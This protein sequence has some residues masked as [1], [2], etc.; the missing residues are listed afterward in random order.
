MS[1]WYHEELWRPLLCHFSNQPHFNSPWICRDAQAK[2]KTTIQP[3][4][5]QGRSLHC[6]GSEP[7]FTNTIY[8]LGW[9]VHSRRPGL[10][11][12]SDAQGL[13]ATS[14]PSHATISFRALLSQEQDLFLSFFL[15]LCLPSSPLSAFLI[16]IFFILSFPFLSKSRQHWLGGMR[17][18]RVKYLGFY[19][20]FPLK[21][22]SGLLE[23]AQLIKS[24]LSDGSDPAA[25][26][27]YSVQRV[28]TTEERAQSITLNLPVK[29]FLLLLL[30]VSFYFTL[31]AIVCGDLPHSK[32]LQIR[33]TDV[34]LQ[35][36][37]DTR[38]LAKWKQVYNRYFTFS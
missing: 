13:D 15:L 2:N 35:S 16:Y 21:K 19:A 28:W 25:P 6:Q 18:H 12:G 26:T 31:K 30:L 9:A 20:F 8:A 38:G 32:R 24:W 22:G 7:W 11:H 3:G 34:Q 5:H 29:I 36:S 23:R 27:N 37:A 4:C 33:D 17:P 1:S 10:G 14:V